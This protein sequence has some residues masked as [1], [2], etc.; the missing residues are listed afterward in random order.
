M[1]T[2]LLVSL[3]SIACTAL[4]VAA[5]SDPSAQFQGFP[6][7]LARQHLGANLLQ[8][9]NTTHMFTPT[10]AAAAWLDDDVTTSW[11]FMAEK[12][13]YLLTLPRPELVTNFAVSTR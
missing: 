9:N 10:Q 6:K 11:P 1:K 4:S 7:N 12:Q 8:Y 2:S 5:E 13:Y 3:A